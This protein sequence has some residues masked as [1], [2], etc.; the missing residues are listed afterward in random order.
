MLKIER[1]DHFVFAG[2]AGGSLAGPQ[3]DEGAETLLQ[4]AA[5]YMIERGRE[6]A[7]AVYKD[8]IK[9]ELAKRMREALWER[10]EREGTEITRCGGDFLAAL[11]LPKEDAVIHIRLGRGALL[12]M[13]EE[14]HVGSISMSRE[15][16]RGSILTDGA[17]GHMRMGVSIL[18]EYRSFYMLEDG[19]ALPAFCAVWSDV[20]GDV[21]GGPLAAGRPGGR[22]EKTILLDGRRTLTCYPQYLFSHSLAPER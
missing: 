4:A 16:A 21:S 5:S 15:R 2:S 18:T 17:V 19:A 12:G 10:A 9:Y 22:Q 11:F 8:E 20:S 3:G 13:T 14:G 1:G 7:A 6:L